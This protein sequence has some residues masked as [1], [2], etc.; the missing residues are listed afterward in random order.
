M[1][2]RAA[3]RVGEEFDQALVVVFDST[4]SAMELAACASEFDLRGRLIPV[5]RSLSS[6]CGIAWR[7]PPSHRANVERALEELALDDARLELL[8]L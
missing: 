1:A 7:E 8:K 2:T 5:P 3:K 4:A 6:G